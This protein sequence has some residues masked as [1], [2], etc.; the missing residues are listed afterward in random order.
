MSDSRFLPRLESVRGL[1]ALAVAYC[2]CGITLIFAARAEHGE[3][4]RRFSAALLRPLGW[5]ANGEAAV[6]VFF[7]LSGLVLSLTLD[8]RPAHR[9]PALYLDFVRRRVLRIYPAHLA[10]LI[11][12]VPLAYFVIY[13]VPMLDPAAVH[14]A[15]D[16]SG[17]WV[18]DSVYGHINRRELV[19]SALLV[20]N[21]YN[22]VTWTLQVELLGSLCLPVFA[23]WSRS[24]RWTIDFAVLA[25]LCAGAAITA[26]CDRPD[27]ASLYLPAFY[28]GC[29][30]RTHGRRLAAVAGRHPRGTG[31]GIL[32][33]L[34]LLL[35]PFAERAP[36]GLLLLPL[37]LSM[38]AAAFGLVSL[39]AWGESRAASGLLLHPAMRL[40]GRLSY[41]FYLW[42]WLLLYSFARLVF[43]V[44]PPP[45]LAEWNLTVL[46]LTFG[47]TV[48]AALAVASLSYRWVERPF[49]ELGRRLGRGPRGPAPSVAAEVATA[50]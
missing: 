26:G 45:L 4:Y 16:A 12:F 19:K 41:S 42:H 33:F 37:D 11:V 13:R 27:L 21:F 3:A 6:I 43:A 2:H 10:A 47:L 44:A 36:K 49:I 34:A 22:P 46:A 39:I 24:G 25:L 29:M 40:T 20:S 23:A 28:L 38:S 50:P 1:A 5:L 32:L 8:R 9:S 17:R 35:G 14:G 7:V 30:A 18:D 15:A 48:A 31:I